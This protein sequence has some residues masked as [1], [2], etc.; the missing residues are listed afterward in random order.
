MQLTLMEMAILMF[1]LLPKVTLILIG[2]RITG[3]KHLQVELYQLI[4]LQTVI[5]QSFLSMQMVI[6]I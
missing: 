3:L 2:M 4:H 6:L 1:Y 5:E